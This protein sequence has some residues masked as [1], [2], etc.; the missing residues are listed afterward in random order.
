M[1]CLRSLHIFLQDFFRRA[2]LHF[3]LPDSATQDV[4]HRQ[5]TET[6]MNE[7]LKA[8]AHRA[9]SLKTSTRLSE[10]ATRDML[11]EL[12]ENNLAIAGYM[13]ERLTHCATSMATFAT[14]QPAR[15]SGSTKPSR[16]TWFL[17]ESGRGFVSAA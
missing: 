11:A 12:R 9:A 10:D 4:S 2:F 17:F 3:H 13:R 15:W 5:V 1:A 14:G 7:E 16:R 6:T 8:V